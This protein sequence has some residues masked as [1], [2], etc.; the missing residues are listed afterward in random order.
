MIIT[1]T[2]PCSDCSV[3][4][5]PVTLDNLAPVSVPVNLSTL[6]ALTSGNAYVGFTAATGAS[7]E[8]QDITSWTFQAQV[9]PEETTVF[10]FNNNNYL[11]TPDADQ[12]DSNH[13]GNADS[14]GSSR[15]QHTCAG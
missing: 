15:L 12:A 11:V 2:P 4:S 9:P 5:L 13:P 8:N 10:Q 6:L 14:E 3:G 1:Y 7:V